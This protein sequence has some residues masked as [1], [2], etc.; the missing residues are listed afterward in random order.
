[1]PRQNVSNCCRSSTVAPLSASA[2]RRLTS[3]KSMI[4]PGAPCRQSTAGSLAQS[5]SPCNRVLGESHETLLYSAPRGFVDQS[6]SRCRFRHLIIYPPVAGD[7]P[8]RQA[9]RFLEIQMSFE[10]LGLS[11]DL[12]RAVAEHGYT[13]PT[14]IQI[15][16]IPAVLAGGDLLAGAQTGTG[17]TAGFVLPILQL[18][19]TRAGATT[20]SGRKPVRVL[21]LAPTRELAAQIEESV[22]VYGK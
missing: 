12:V 4:D 3:S 8:S 19:S 5:Q 14:P 17:K 13:I 21:I 1:M 11:A 2:M 9:D 16:A 6:P 10:N 22:R 15:Q 18:L 7:L 20:A